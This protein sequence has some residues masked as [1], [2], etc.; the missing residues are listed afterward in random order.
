M[1]SAFSNSNQTFS[2]R[3]FSSK[4]DVFL[5]FSGKDVREGF[6]TN[7][8]NA[9]TDNGI[10]TFKDDVSIERGSDIPEELFKGI[11]ESVCAVVIFSKNYASSSWCLDELEKIVECNQN[12]SMRVLPIFYDVKATV[13]R[14]QKEEYETTFA[15]HE[16]M[17]NVD[18]VAEWRKALFKVANCSGWSRRKY[19]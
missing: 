3:F 12:N 18:K 1:S 5:T 9:L 8:Y 17:Y 2:R 10:R 14:H 7:L 4:H 11:E 13:V 15:N 19:G 16:G 6:L